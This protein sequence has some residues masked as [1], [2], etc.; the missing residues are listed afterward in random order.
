MIHAQVRDDVTAF[1]AL[2]K[3]GCFNESDWTATVYC[4]C[5]ND[6]SAKKSLEQLSSTSP[7]QCKIGPSCPTSATS[8]QNEH[9]TDTD[10]DTKPTKKLRSCIRKQNNNRSML[11]TFQK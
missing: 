1:S 4:C 3:A 5:V 7:S 11:R 6:L 10:T 9:L 2:T 8:V